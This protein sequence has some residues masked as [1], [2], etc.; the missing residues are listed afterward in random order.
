MDLS[1]KKISFFSIGMT[2]EEAHAI[3]QELDMV[4]NIRQE[5]AKKY[6][7]LNELF[8]LLDRRML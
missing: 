5:T 4:V 3:A 8:G 2:P 1:E 7:K 6:P